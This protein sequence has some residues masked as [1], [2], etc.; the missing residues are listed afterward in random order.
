MGAVISNIIDKTDVVGQIGRKLGGGNSILPTA[1][2]WM[3]DPKQAVRKTF[4]GG[5]Q[6]PGVKGITDG[7]ENEI[8]G[9]SLMDKMT[10]EEQPEFISDPNGN[11]FLGTVDPRAFQGTQEEKTSSKK[12]KRAS[13][14]DR[15]RANKSSNIF[16]L[17]DDGYSDTLLGGK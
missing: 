5:P 14:P 1:S 4:L 9:F 12:I 7:V 13:G 3:S 8:F 11:D 10:G 15:R 16:S 6:I 17:M 2:D